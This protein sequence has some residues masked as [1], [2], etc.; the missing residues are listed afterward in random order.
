MTGEARPDRDALLAGMPKGAACAEIGVWKGDFSR[1][2]LDRT[3]PRELHLIDP[4]TFRADLPDRMYGGAVA[5][6]QEEMDAIHRGV[7]RRFADEA[8]V[9]IHRAPSAEALGAFPDGAL[10]WAYVDG[11]HGYEAVLAD[12]GACRRAVRP[13]GRI[14]GD[15]YTWGEALG[16]PVRRAVLAFAEAEGLSGALERFGSQFVFRV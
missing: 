14:A 13:G 11:D 3:A 7:V 2:I 5:G 15:D 9:R 16:F 10:D 12:L 6:S 8:A 1:S 4:W